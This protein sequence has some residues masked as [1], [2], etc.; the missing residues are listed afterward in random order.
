VPLT[1]NGPPVEPDTV[2]AD[3][4]PSPQ[5]MVAEY[6]LAV[7][8]V[9]GSVKVATVPLNAMPSVALT[10]APV[11]A[12]C[13]SAGEVT[14]IF[15]VGPVGA[16]AVLPASPPALSK[17][18]PGTRRTV[19]PKCKETLPFAGTVNGPVHIRCWAAT[20]GSAVV[21]PVVEPAV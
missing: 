16:T 6:S 11:A 3:V 12:I 20:A 8:A 10:A 15:A 4:E 18:S 9:S 19:T 14:V 1:V 7:A 5:A 21:T 17:W 2:P 13:A